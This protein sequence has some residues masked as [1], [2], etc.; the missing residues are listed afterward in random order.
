M[1]RIITVG[2]LATALSAP[3][4]AVDLTCGLQFYDGTAMGYY[5]N[6][7]AQG[8]LVEVAVE[9]NGSRLN[10][11]PDRR[12]IWEVESNAAGAIMTYVPD[13]RYSIVLTEGPRVFKGMWASPAVIAK[14]KQPLGTGG[15]GYPLREHNRR[16]SP[17]PER[18]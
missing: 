10:H 4:M 18:F 17:R 9:K 14:G 8:D 3:A 15:C 2:I 16:S 7:D 11:A 5:F 6:R 12:P 1:R 13:C